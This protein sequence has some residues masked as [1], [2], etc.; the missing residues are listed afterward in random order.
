MKP[1][2]R[3]FLEA[4]SVKDKIGVAID[5]DIAQPGDLNIVTDLVQ[6]G[7]IV[8]I[9]RALLPH[10]GWF[11]DG[12]PPVLVRRGVNADIYQ[13]TLKGIKLCNENG[14]KQR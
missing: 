2:W 7:I 1:E 3:K 13:L 12:A 11:K 14:I 8:W 10:V 9:D 6:E 4:R 5:C